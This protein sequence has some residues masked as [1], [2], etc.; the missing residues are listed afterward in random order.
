LRLTTVRSHG[1]F[2][3][4]IYEFNDRYRGVFGRRD[5]VLMHKDDMAAR[6]IEHG[7]LVD[8]ETALPV[9]TRLRMAGLTAVEHDIARGSVAT[10]FPEANILVPLSWNDPLS[11]TPSYKSV[12]VRI[13]RA[14]MLP[15]T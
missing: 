9:A 11:G 6:Q 15:A 1:Q 12:P 5:V 10:Y 13:A 3:T 4:T 2:N 8:V 14:G 7:C